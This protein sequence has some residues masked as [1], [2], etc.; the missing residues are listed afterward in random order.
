MAKA[1]APRRIALALQGGGSHGV[2]TWGV[3]DRRLE[4]ETLKSSASR[5]PAPGD[6][7][8]VMADGR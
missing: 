7:R 4:D 8:W 2:F 6:E 3:L 1:K 5:A